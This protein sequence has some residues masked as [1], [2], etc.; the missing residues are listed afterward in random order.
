VADLTNSMKSAVELKTFRPVVIAYLDILGDPIAM[1]T[2]NG[3]FAPSGGSDPVLNGK[4]YYRSESF[5][6]VSEIQ[7]DEGIGAP[8][9]ITLKANDLDESA[10]RQV[11]RDKR[12]W[13]GRKAYIWLGIYDVDGKTVLSEPTR[14]KTGILSEAQITRAAGDVG[15][16]FSIDSDLQNAKSAPLRYVE[17]QKIFAGDAFSS[18]MVELG[19]KPSGFIRSGAAGGGSGGGDYMP[20]SPV[21]P[22]S[23]P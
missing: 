21:A 7:Q 23:P 16:Q 4:V 17:H 6:N 2:G 20:P 19:N 18:F 1:W 5:A 8:V 3:D 15:L 11:I 12:K 10:L 14:I 13:L 22:W 9:I